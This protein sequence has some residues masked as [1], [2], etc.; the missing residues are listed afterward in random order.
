MESTTNIEQNE[1]RCN[2]GHPIFNIINNTT[3]RN[4]LR[5]IAFGENTYG[6]RLASILNISS[7]AV[8]RHLKSLEGEPLDD[9]NMIKEVM[10]TKEYSGKKGAA[11][12]MFEIDTKV[13]L[14]FSIFPNYIHS[15]IYQRDK[16]NMH[17][18]NQT[19]DQKYFLLRNVELPRLDLSDKKDTDPKVAKLHN[20]HGKIAKLNQQ[21][22]ELQN[23]L[24][25]VLDEKNDMMG[26]LNN[27]VNDL[28]DLGYEEKVILRV[29]IS[30]GGGCSQNILDLLHIDEYIL[31][32]Y[33]DN[34]IA[35]GW[36]SPSSALP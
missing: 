3:R 27:F 30:L 6:N 25:E 32:K 16:T 18:M 34:L 20:F 9:F 7:T 33:L 35:K 11:A 23:E 12:S 8:H 28:E 24:V 22:L 1:I 4:I 15:Q 31:Q 26:E 13:T 5:L 21:I 14:F 17:L 10:K 29:M 36:L 19:I 2:F